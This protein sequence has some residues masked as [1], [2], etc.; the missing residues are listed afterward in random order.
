VGRV[1]FGLPDLFFVLKSLCIL[2]ESQ[3][4]KWVLTLLFAVPNQ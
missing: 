1:A 3:L 4:V 2:D